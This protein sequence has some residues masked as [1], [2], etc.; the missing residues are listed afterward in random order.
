VDHNA[1]ARQSKVPTSRLGRLF[2]FGMMAGELATGGI[3]EGVKRLA[4]AGPADTASAFLNPRNAQKLAQRL[5]HMRG[6]AMKLGQLLSLH[7]GRSGAVGILSGLAL[8]R[9][10]ANPMPATQLKRLLNREYGKDWRRRFAEFDV[11]PLAAASIGQVHRARTADGRDLAL[12]IQYPG[13]A[14]SIDSD[15]DNVAVLLRL[16]NVLPV[17]LDVSGLIAEAKRQLH[18]EADYLQEA[19]FLDHFRQ[20]VA[21]E[22][23]LLVPRV[24]DDLTTSHILAMGLRHGNPLEA[25]SEPDVSKINGTRPVNSSSI[26]CSGNCSNFAL[27]RPTP[28][29]PT[30]FFSPKPAKSCCWTLA[31]CGNFPPTSSPITPASPAPSS[32]ATG[33]PWR[34]RQRHWLPQ[35]RRSERPHTRRHRSDDAD[36]RT[37]ESP[38]PIRFRQLPGCRFEPANWDSTW[39][40]GAVIC[41]RRRRRPCFSTVSWSVRFWSAPGFGRGSM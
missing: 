28:T 13:V 24:H 23:N 31:R 4:N 32:T 37:P 18:Q 2:S 8:L 9:A 30:T 38:G 26:C 40:F 16:L 41:A 39:P 6:A 7:G 17:E 33:P 12:K 27:C 36:L 25:L 29:S 34:R 22:P 11:T 19:R 20:L 15:V 21:D 3:I 5:S 1:P 14:R 35:F 10:G